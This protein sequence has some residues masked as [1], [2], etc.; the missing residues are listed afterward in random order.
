MVDKEYIRRLKIRV[1]IL[2]RINGLRPYD[3][4]LVFRQLQIE[5][6]RNELEKEWNYFS[7]EGWFSGDGNGNYL[8][9]SGK[10]GFKA[11]E[12][13]F[14]RISSQNNWDLKLDRYNKY[15][16]ILAVIISGIALYHS[17]S[18]DGNYKRIE[19]LLEKR[20]TDSLLFSTT[21]RDLENQS[22]QHSSKLQNIQKLVER[23][24]S[25]TNRLMFDKKVKKK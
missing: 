13:E 25:L 21:L 22:A 9:D 8:N 5:Y 12:K 19:T 4:E 18:Q 24:D 14:K 2:T 16:S 15:G 11:I 10:N 3:R 23:N 20:R 1:E 6:D 17:C 7:S